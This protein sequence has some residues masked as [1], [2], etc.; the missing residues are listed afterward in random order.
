MRSVSSGWRASRRPASL[1]AARL[2][3][4]IAARA[5]FEALAYSCACWVPHREH[6]R[7]LLCK[8]EG[9]RVCGCR[10]AVYLPHSLLLEDHLGGA[11]PPLKY[12]QSLGLA[13]VT[14]RCGGA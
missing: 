2:A 11:D 6:A 1:I 7:G 5:C 10:A 13:H 4:F 3:D 9:G 12:V 8:R 14:C